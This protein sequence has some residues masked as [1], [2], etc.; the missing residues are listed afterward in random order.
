MVYVLDIL[1][2]DWFFALSLFFAV[3]I[4][5]NGKLERRIRALL[6]VAGILSLLGLAGVPLGDM[7]IRN[8][9]IVSYAVVAP[10]AFL[11]MGVNFHRMIRDQY[12]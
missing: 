6:L 1:A 3:P 7:Q 4:F 2:W 9:G 12:K 10:F 5:C 8:I 11:L